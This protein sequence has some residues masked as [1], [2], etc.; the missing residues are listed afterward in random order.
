M[1]EL[2]VL[3]LWNELHFYASH[4]AL[5]TRPLRRFHVPHHRSLVTTPWST[6]S[7][8]PVEALL[9]GSVPLIP[10]L[11]HD[12]SFTALALLPLFSI[13]INNLGHSNYEFSAREK[14]P[15]LQGAS[16]RHHLHHTRYHGNYGFLAAW[17]DRLFRSALRD[18]EPSRASPRRPRA[19]A[20]GPRAEPR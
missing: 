20:A 9:L 7:F 19:D 5:H 17:P 10:M 3:A 6:Y 16:R 12:F 4:R 11:L 14:P 18:D 15:G 1:L 2:G 8:H 13:V